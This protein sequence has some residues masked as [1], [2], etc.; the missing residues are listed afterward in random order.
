[1]L[2]APGC[3]AKPRPPLRPSLPASLC[4]GQGRSVTTAWLAANAPLAHIAK[5]RARAWLDKLTLDLRDLD[6]NG[7]P[8]KRK[9]AELLSAYVDLYETADAAHRAAIRT[10]L[11]VIAATTQEPWYHDM[12]KVDDATFSRD[13]TSYLRIALFMDRAGLDTT[14]YRKQIEKIRA[15]LDRDM[16]KRGYHQQMMF[17]NYYHHFGLKEPYRLLEATTVGVIPNRPSPYKLTQNEVYDL[18]HEVGA[19]YERE[20]K[21][22]EGVFLPADLAYL[23]W[24]LDRLT[25][26]Y[27][28]ADNRDLV[29]ELAISLAYLGF[30][31]LAVFREAMGALLQSQNPDGSWG[32]YEEARATYGARLDVAMYLHTTAIAMR[33]LAV[34]F[35]TK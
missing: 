13:S 26:R 12:D 16:P 34:T 25:V 4:E 17:H 3:K 7:I 22:P 33:A 24:A 30:T 1:L 32:V 29:G 18:T 19:R 14:G 31:D 27:L 5:A 20:D 8:G 28:M 6:R 10:R 23:R 2:A 9:L 35:A 21:P 15:R 11:Q